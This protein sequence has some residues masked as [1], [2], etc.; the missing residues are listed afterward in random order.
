MSV[1]ASSAPDRSLLDREIPLGAVMLRLAP[2]L[3]VLILTALPRL[4]GL[5]SYPLAPQEARLAWD[6]SRLVTGGDLTTAGWTQPL[7]TASAALAFFLFGPGDGAARLA[8]LLAGF[9]SVALAIR[10][11]QRIDPLLGWASGILLALSPTFVV[12]STRLDG[13]MVLISLALVLASVL[14]RPTPA[15]SS[16]FVLGLLLGTAPLAHPLGWIVLLGGT[17][18]VLARWSPRGRNLAS[19]AVGAL[20]IIALTSTFLFTRPDGFARF[21]VTSW[22][23]LVTEF[24]GQPFAA[25]SRPLVLLAT[26]EF[27]ILALALGGT[28]LSIRRRTA[29]GLVIVASLGIASTVLF[30]NGRTS[31]LALMVSATIFLAGYG[32]CQ[33]LRA[34]PWSTLRRSW[35]SAV[36]GMSALAL[37]LGLS[38]IGRLLSGPQGDAFAWLAGIVS[39]V[40]LLLVTLWMIQQLWRR[41]VAPRRLPLI[42]PLLA[43]SILA[44]RDAMLANATTTYRPGTVLHGEDSAPGLRTTV[45]RLRR[46]SMDL[47]MFQFD[48]RDPT[49]GHGLVIV[50]H[51]SVSQPFAWYLRDFPSLRIVSTSGLPVA[52]PDAQVIVIP[53]ELHA[54]IA[55]ARPELVWQPVPAQLAVPAVLRSPP[56]GRLVTGIVDP[57]DWREFVSFLLYRRIAVPNLPQTVLVGLVPEVATR[58]GYSAVP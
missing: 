49:G 13:T 57:R 47:T 41:A 15:R 42:L 46:V 17:A 5:R 4:Y 34:V 2:W 7:P 26:E 37:L 10:L 32:L 43:L 33:L 1:P 18:L 20:L 6:A 44:S 22:Q 24:L 51:D 25:W 52:L 19:L 40:L 9:A 27:P 38:L 31:A 29:R 3:A 53:P 21:L 36:L 56:W 11:G 50:L 30:G 35:E 58:A 55:A 14:L 48:P 28:I 23:T 39:L 12:A 8:S 54:G 45:D 16:A